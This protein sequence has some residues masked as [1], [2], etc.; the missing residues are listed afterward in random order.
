LSFPLLPILTL[1]F[2]ALPVIDGQTRL[3]LGIPIRFK[4]A[5]KV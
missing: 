1:I 3:M 2:L 5:R 4:V